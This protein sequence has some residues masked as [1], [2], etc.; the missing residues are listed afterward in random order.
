[1]RAYRLPRDSLREFSEVLKVFLLAVSSSWTVSQKQTTRND[2]V[3][4]GCLSK[5][6]G[7][8]NY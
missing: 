6:F 3:V 5:T 2:V 7:D 8:K 4:T 1:V